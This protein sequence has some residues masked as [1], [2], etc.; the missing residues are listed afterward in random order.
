MAAAEPRDRK[1]LRIDGVAFDF[2][3]TLTKPGSI[4][5]AAVH[6]AIGCPREKGLLEFLAAIDDP[7]ERAQKEAVLTAA[8]VEAAARCQPN[9][10]LSELVAMLREA[11]VPLAIITRNRRE[12]IERALS[13]LEGVDAEDFACLVTRDIP[14]APKPSP[15]SVLHVARALGLEVGRILVVGDHPYDIEAGF[16]A[17][18]LTMFLRNGRD[19]AWSNGPVKSDFVVDDLSEAREVICEGLL[20]SG[21]GSS[22]RG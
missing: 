19:Q 4:D 12:P 15:E 16:R 11:A 17:G 22:V 2:D 13:H 1:P 9:P 21:R 7:D 20:R 6:E 5:F 14:L 3:G 18:A 10:G 8:E